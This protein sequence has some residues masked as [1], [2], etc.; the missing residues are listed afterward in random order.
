MGKFID[1]TGKKFGRLTVLNRVEE[2]KN[3]QIQ[4][5]CKCEC[6]KEVIVI[7][8]N[9]KNGTSKSCGCIRRNKAKKPNKYDLTKEYGIGYTHKNEVFYFDLDDYELI[10]NHCWNKNED[11][12]LVSRI[13]DKIIRMH[14]LIMNAP[15]DKDVDHINHLIYDNRKENLRIVTRSQNNMNRGLQINSTS[16]IKGVN[17]CKSK[18]KWKAVIKLNK[19]NIHLEYFVQKEDAIKARTEAEEKYFGEYRYN[20]NKYL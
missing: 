20:Q 12:Y 13:N 3:K 4:W 19:R 14:R 11:G 16:G 5:F 18:E 8:N 17:Y 7:G 10:K 2:K 9:L 1:I 6:G 15:K